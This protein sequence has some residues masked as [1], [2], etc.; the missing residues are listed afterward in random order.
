[1]A[2]AAKGLP[3][4]ASARQLDPQTIIDAI[5]AF[6]DAWQEGKRP[7]KDVLDPDIA[8]LAMG[9]LWASKWFDSFSGSGA[10]SSSTITVTQRHP[11]SCLP[12]RALAI[13]PIHFLKGCFQDSRVD[14]TVAVF[15]LLVANEPFIGKSSPKAKDYF[16]LMDGVGRIVPKR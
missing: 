10:L 4:C 3:R 1:M 14:C 2:R 15:N 5:D 7:S 6:V 8:H 13:Y 12:D 11:A 16:N 9:S